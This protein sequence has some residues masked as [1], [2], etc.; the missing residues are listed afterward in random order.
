MNNKAVTALARTCH[1]LRTLKV[2]DG[3]LV[4]PDIVPQLQPATNLSCLVLGPGAPLSLDMVTQLLSGLPTLTELECY[5]VQYRNDS[6]TASW[7]GEYPSLRRL[8]LVNGTT[9]SSPHMQIV[10]HPSKRSGL[11]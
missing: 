7:K 6:T 8:K 3:G 4:S 9:H 1:N 10:S 5:H 11:F 2:L